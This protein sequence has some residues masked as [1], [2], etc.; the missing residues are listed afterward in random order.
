MS[1]HNS[2]EI[3]WKQLGETPLQALERL[4][5]E[6]HLSDDIKLTYA[7]RLDPL[8]EGELLVLI[9]EECKKKEE[10][11]VLDKEYEVEI[12]LGTQTDTGDVMGKIVSHSS[13]FEYNPRLLEDINKDFKGKVQWAYPPFSS[14]TVEGKPLFLWSLE[15]KIDEITIPVRESEIYNLEVLGERLVTVSELRSTVHTK[16]NSI[17]PVSKDIESKRLGADF[18][19]GEVLASWAE[20][21]KWSEGV[22]DHKMPVITIR[23]KC[24][25]G[26]YMRTLAQKIGEKL[27]MPALALSIVRTEIYMPE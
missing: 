27:N 12:L 10:Y 22:S 25:S 26:T 9:G 24:S 7:G 2:T 21:F 8:A 17:T 1:T 23:C 3:I 14:K 13:T 18:R 19:R 15:G 16:I 4:R 11:L 5:K 6:K 20:F